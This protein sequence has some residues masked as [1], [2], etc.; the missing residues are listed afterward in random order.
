M[1]VV[2]PVAPRLH[3]LDR[4][5]AADQQVAGVQAEADVTDIER[6]LDLPHRFKER[7][8]VVMQCRL[9]AALAAALDHPG[10]ALTKPAPAGVIPPDAAGPRRRGR[11]VASLP[12]A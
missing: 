3:P 1:H 4:V 2:D 12:R 7:A 8:G 6:P 10:D 11:P 9:V 5:T